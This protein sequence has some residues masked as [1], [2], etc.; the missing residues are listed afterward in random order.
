MLQRSTVHLLKKRGYKKKEIARMVGCHR[1]TVSKVLKERPDKT[2]KRKR[3]PS[4]VDIYWDK[5]V[6]WLEE[7]VPVARMLEMAKE[8]KENPY[9]G[10]KS[11]FYDRVKLIREEVE[12]EKNIAIWRFEGL[13]GEYLQV[14]WGKIPPKYLKEKRISYKYI[15]VAR[16]KYS[17]FVFIKF[18]H[19][20]DEETIIRCILSC[21]E[22][23]G[24]VPWVLVFDNIKTVTTGRSSEGNPIWNRTF[25]KFALEIG[26]HPDV[27]WMRSPNQKGGVESGVKYVKTNFFPGREFANDD[28][29]LKQAE[30]WMKRI[31][32]KK[33]QATGKLPVEMLKEEKPHFLPLL[34]NAKDYGIMLICKVTPSSVVHF[35]TNFYSVPEKYINCKVQVRVRKERIDIYHQNTLISSHK[36]CFEKRRWIRCLSHYQKTFQKKPR[37]FSM[38][39]REKL[40]EKNEVISS[41]IKEIVRRYPYT[42]QKDVDTLYHLLTAHGEEKLKEAI[43][44]AAKYD[45][46]GGSY[47]EAFLEN[48]LELVP[49]SGKTSSSSLTFYESYVRGGEF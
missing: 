20:M 36:R 15:F 11:A 16:L 28:D 32:T 45:L 33:N 47:V 31:N 30:E 12:K 40:L 21:F 42:W 35:E 19:T 6:K 48:S 37:A 38:A 8:D 2:Y 1:N 10:G 23:I 13:P 44:K 49:V 25:L 14:D 26:F 34:E 24:G 43:L 5:I 29:L 22:A 27:C 18:T 46:F 39:K 4:Q 17:R 7:K 9:Q 3:I 41:Y